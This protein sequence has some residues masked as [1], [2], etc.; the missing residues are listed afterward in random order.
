MRSLVCCRRRAK[1]ISLDFEEHDKVMTYDGLE[2]CILNS[3]KYNSE[4]SGLSGTTGTTTDFSLDEETSSCT[5]SPFLPEQWDNKKDKKDK[6]S[7]YSNNYVNKILLN[8]GKG[9]EISYVMNGADL[10][11]MKDRFAKLL[12]GEDVLGGA[13]GFSTA[14]ALSHAI[15]N[16]SSTVFGELWKLEPLCEEKKRRWKMEMDWFL[17]PTNYMVELVPAQQS[18][19]NG[20][21]LEI[22]TPK[23]RSDVHVNLP[24]L[25]KL[26][27]MLIEVLDSMTGTEFW[28]EECGTKSGGQNGQQK[29]SKRWWIP[30]PRVPESGLSE[31]SRKKLIFHAKLVHQVLKAAKSINEQ[32]LLQMILP[33]SAPNALPKTGK[34]SLGQDMYQV[35]RTDSVSIEEIFVSFNFQNEHSVLDTMNRL[36]TAVF[37]WR[38][39][40]IDEPSKKS[41]Y[42]RYFKKDGSSETEKR[43]IYMEKAESLLHLI[44][45]RFPNLPQTFMDVIKVQYNTD[46]GHS[47]VEAYS[48]V[49]VGLAF[50]ILSRMSEILMEDDLKKPTTPISNLKFDFASA[51]YL[52][53]ITETPP[54][55]IRRSL[56][57]Q[58]NKVDGRLSRKKG[59][60]QLRW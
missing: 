58:M 36:E 60:K 14:L 44:K 56:I 26:D 5:S 42:K 2:S 28:Y 23:A 40:A 50:S 12:L 45:S 39:R 7:N 53:G 31:F 15:T 1:D 35:I 22:M 20:C 11:A 43:G 49:L 18:G 25:Q 13:K 29:Q 17:S 46:I 24:A 57:D 54:G 16:L 4:E 38:Q 41:P 10:D 9:V 51:V 48:R 59:G 47:I 33:P 34:E 6:D 30:S 32:V 27:S 19:A 21:M 52:S 8:K 55:H 3:C 37:A